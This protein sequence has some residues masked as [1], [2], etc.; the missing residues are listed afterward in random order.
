MT[1]QQSMLRGAR[2]ISS[3]LT[4]ATPSQ[5][6]EALAERNLFAAVARH[7]GKETS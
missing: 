2:S 6:A 1:A 4:G 5:V 3:T 7:Q